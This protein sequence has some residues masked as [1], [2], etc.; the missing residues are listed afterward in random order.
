MAW[1]VGSEFQRR[2][3][4]R[5]NTVVMNGFTA[6]QYVKIIKKY[7]LTIP[8]VSYILH[9]GIFLFTYSVFDIELVK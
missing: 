9:A 8:D 2:H 6:R 1:T 4:K 3:G 7:L 5:T